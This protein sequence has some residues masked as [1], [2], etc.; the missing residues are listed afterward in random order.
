MYTAFDEYLIHQ[1]SDTVDHVADGDPR[2]QERVF[3]NAH[4]RPG[5]SLSLGIGSFP[6]ANVMQGYVEF[7]D[8]QWRRTLRL[9]RVLH[10]D[11]E[12]L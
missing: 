6:N 8:G 4:G 9:A 12:R 3:F 10:H 11:R 5:P 7:V 1:T 2:F